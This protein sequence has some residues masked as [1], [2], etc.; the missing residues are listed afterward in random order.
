MASLLACSDESFSSLLDLF[1]CCPSRSVGVPRTTAQEQESKLPSRVLTVIVGPHLLRDVW[2]EY[3]NSRLHL[4]WAIGWS[5][6]ERDQDSPSSS[7]CVHLPHSWRFQF[8][9]KTNEAKRKY[10]ELSA[11]R[12][13]AGP[14][15]FSAL[16]IFFFFTFIYLCLH[17]FGCL[18]ILCVYSE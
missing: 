13:C 12:P 2:L 11:V 8:M 18:F 9:P 7:A 3:G 16:T 14:Q 15:S 5:E 6:M 4:P 17:L 1:Q 10:R